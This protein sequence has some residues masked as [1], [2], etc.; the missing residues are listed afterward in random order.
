MKK[1][2]V[3]IVDDAALI[4]RLVSDA[5]AGDPHIEVAGAAGNGKQALQMIPQLNPDLVTLDVEM[6][7]MGGIETLRELRKRYP[8]LPV[9]MFSVLTER[10]CVDTLEA[11]SLGASD[12]VAKPATAG[13]REAAQQRIRED[14]VPRIKSLC[15]VGGATPGSA[16]AIP[17]ARR[18]P[19]YPLGTIAKG[20]DAEV[21][22]IAMALS[23]GGP[24]A[25]ADVLGAL[26]ETFPAAIAIV[27]HMPQAFTKLLAERLNRQVKV[28]VME[29]TDGGIVVP[30]TVYVA[31]GDRH[32]RF[33][34]RGPH[35]VTTLE[36]DVPGAAQ[37]PSADVL[38]K[39]IAELYGGHALALVMTGG[40]EDGLQGSD[41]ITKAGGRVIV[42]DEATSLVWEMAGRVHRAGL[43][44]A[45]LPL[46]EIGAELVRR[47]RGTTPAPRS[48][49][50]A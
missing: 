17:P 16:A 26:P 37:R 45:A 40:G 20:G 30:G 11:L 5:L 44:D 38:F 24:G 7:E 47:T 35:I 43:A 18:A 36:Q 14:L 8:R 39:S 41:A 22:A 25:L 19:V 9:I 46:A 31:P 21:R 32:L 48:A 2:R 10:G 33:V 29:A 4:R 15:R 12:Y 34:R 28:P 1:A 3:L 42:Q 13:G 23:T 50:R 6:P 27:L 49:V